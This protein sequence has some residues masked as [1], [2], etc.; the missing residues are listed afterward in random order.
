MRLLTLLVLFLIYPFP[1]DNVAV[2]SV[3]AVVVVRPTQYDTERYV[4]LVANVTM[5]LSD[6]W[7]IQ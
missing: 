2:D 4:S 7:P 6:N 1:V 5:H 3:A